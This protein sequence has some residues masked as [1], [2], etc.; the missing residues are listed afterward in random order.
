MS[1]NVYCLSTP[2]KKPLSP[3]KLLG[4][5]DHLPS[6]SPEREIC[7][8]TLPLMNRRIDEVQKEFIRSKVEL[9]KSS[10]TGSPFVSEI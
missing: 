9:G 6:S 3:K 8:R 1:Q 2:K 4:Y 10:V 5:E 7:R